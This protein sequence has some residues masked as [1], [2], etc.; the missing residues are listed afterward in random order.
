MKFLSLQK[1]KNKFCNKSF[2]ICRIQLNV[3]C[4]NLEFK[5]KSNVLDDFRNK[6]DKLRLKLFNAS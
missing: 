3:E 6:Y 1:S 2:I 4:K 5:R